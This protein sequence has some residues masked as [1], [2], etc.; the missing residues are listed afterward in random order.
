[1]SL[2]K[3]QYTKL[4]FNELVDEMFTIYLP[5]QIERPSCPTKMYHYFI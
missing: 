4:Q 2:A 1:M 5:V 3:N